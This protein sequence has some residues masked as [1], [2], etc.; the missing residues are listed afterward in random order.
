M[1]RPAHECALKSGPR[2][3]R[4]VVELGAATHGFSKKE[5]PT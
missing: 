4:A 5:R 3:S 2:P 1:G